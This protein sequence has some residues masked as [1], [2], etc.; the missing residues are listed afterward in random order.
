VRVSAPVLFV[1]CAI[2]AVGSL[3]ACSDGSPP[4]LAPSNSL[5]QDGAMGMNTSVAAQTGIAVR[6]PNHGRSWMATN[7]KAADLLYVS[8]LYGED[9]LVYS[10]PQGKLVGTLTGITEPDGI[11]PDKKG[12]VWIVSHYNATIYEFKHGG[13]KPIAT[14]FD[15]GGYSNMCSVDPTTGNLAVTNKFA[16]GYGQGSI[17]IFAHA[18]GTPQLYYDPKMFEVYFCGYDP[19]GN[20]FVDGAPSSVGFAFAELPKGKKTFT[21]ITLKGGTIYFPGDVFWDG[22]YVAVGDQTYG[23]GYPDT[24][25]IYQ[26]TGAG[27]KIVHSTVLTGSGDVVEFWINGKT[28]I[29]ADATMQEAGFYKY[30]AGG[31]AFKVLKVGTSSSPEGAAISPAH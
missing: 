26:T 7:A 1:L 27:G 12:D 3:A 9:V 16:Y 13:T 17:A 21:N 28:V 8:D 5:Q 11:C 10:Y 31:K 2:I 23:G 29:G 6:H 30:P 4:R 20:L 24:S 19:K 15:P 22:R 25:A 18:K 14:L